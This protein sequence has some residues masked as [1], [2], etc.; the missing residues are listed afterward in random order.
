[1][2][3]RHVNLSG[4]LAVIFGLAVLLF[5]ML[6]LGA[7]LVLGLTY[8]FGIVLVADIGQVIAA[9]G[10]E[11]SIGPALIATPLVAIAVAVLASFW[12]FALAQLW[13]HWLAHGRKA[14]V[15]LSALPLILPRFGLGALFLLSALQLAQS[16]GNIMGLGLVVLAQAAAATPLVAGIHCLGQRR[17]DPSLRKAALEAGAGEDFVFRRLTLPVLRPYLILAALLAFL[18][19]FGDFYLGNALAGEASLL[20]SVLFSGV[21]RNAS[22]LYQALVA[23]VLIAELICV[24]I[25]ARQLRALPPFNRVPAP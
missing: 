6:P 18:L 13:R 15:L 3:F 7:I 22:P 24:V 17:I 10:Q 9:L 4:L 2:I 14:F 19:S 5:L 1:M 12:G 8:I 21:A 20:P 11:G 16:G 23:V 25:L